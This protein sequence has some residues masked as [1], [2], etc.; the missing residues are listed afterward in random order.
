MK[1]RNLVVA[2]AAFL[3]A[4]GGAVASTF[5]PQ[6]IWV[7]ARLTSGGNITCVNTSQNCEA[8]GSNVCQVRVN[9]TPGGTAIAKTTGPFRTYT[10]SDCET[11]L[12]NTNDA[13]QISSVSVFELI[14]E[15]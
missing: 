6:N 12:K 13:V 14:S 2:A 7:K 11:L 9:L 4:I 3:V 15:P 5:A 10:A 8:S 1:S